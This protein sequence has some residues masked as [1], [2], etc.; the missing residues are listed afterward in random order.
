VLLADFSGHGVAA[1][2]NT[3]LLH[4]LVARTMPE[5]S[6]PA[7]WLAALNGALHKIL[8]GGHFATAFLGILDIGLGQLSFSTAASPTAMV[9]RAGTGTEIEMIDGSGPLLGP[10]PA[11]LFE[12]RTIALAP[13]ESL[14][15]YSD[16]LA[17]T[18]DSTDFVDPDG[19]V[20]DRILGVLAEPRPLEALVEQ[21]YQTEKR[22]PRDD[23]TVIWLARR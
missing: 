4:S 1:A 23:L 17:E 13:G 2:I 20:R 5:N 12:T 8:P 22:P 14:V 18:R 11:P 9:V 10:L 3:F 6:D 19:R 15:L 21:F 7:S 16:A